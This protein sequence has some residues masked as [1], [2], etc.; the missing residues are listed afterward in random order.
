MAFL[1]WFDGEL[2]P[3][4]WLDAELQPAAWWDAE[5]VLTSLG[6]ANQTLSPGLLVN[7]AAFFAPTVTPGAAALTPALL[8]HTNTLLPPMVTPQAVALTAPLL[9]NV[10]TLSAPVVGVGS[11]SLLPTLLSSSAVLF[12]PGVSP[13]AVDLAPVL[14]VNVPALYAPDVALVGGGAQALTPGVV[15]TNSQTFFAPTVATGAVALS[16]P[17]LINTSVVYAATVTPQAVTLA[18]LKLDNTNALYVPDISTRWELTAAFLNNDNSLWPPSVQT[19]VVDLQAPLLVNGQQWF[20]PE[21]DNRV[22]LLTSAQAQRLY[23]VVLL[24][25]LQVGAPLSISQ[26]QRLAG[27][28]EQAIT[29]GD[30]AVTIT[31]L[32]TPHAT[33]LEVGALVDDLA[34]WYG[35]GSPVTLTSTSHVGGPI[36]Q[37]LASA[38][39]V[40][41][42]VRQ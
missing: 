28:L 36:S 4:A 31:T 37:T 32:A 16:P 33:G 6:D 25:G 5:L 18:P 15:H 3:D 11:V 19:G 10:S 12:V 8:A 30:G 22:Y 17:C 39:G 23:Q 9:T 27:G 2:R 35:L 20:A 29:E 38:S 24:H 34:A 14:L 26:T 42:V 40:T 7:V 21:V 13:G 41:T 1:S